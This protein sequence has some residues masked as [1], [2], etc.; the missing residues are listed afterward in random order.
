MLMRAVFFGTPAIAVP[1]LR[2]LTEI[3]HVRAVVCQ[4][5]RPAGRGL[6]LRPPPV[7]AAAQELNLVVHQPKAVKTGALTQWLKEL[8]VDVALVMAYGRILPLD[9]L[10]APR[11]GSLNLHASLL[12]KYRGAAPIQW[13][14]AHGEH[15]TGISLMRMEAGMDTGPVFCRRAVAIGPEETAGQ[16]AERLSLLAAEV[17]RN[18]LARTLSGE[19]V[20]IPQD[21]AAA[22]YAP[23]IDRTTAAVQWTRRAPEIMN[24]V[25]AMAPRPGAHTRI[26]NKELKL[27]QVTCTSGSAFPPGHVSLLESGRVLVAC[28]E[29]AIEIHRAQ[30]EGRR[31]ADARD[32][33]NGRILRSGDTLGS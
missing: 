16:L 8:E 32:L 14:I 31:V 13:A 27:W 18:D 30:L 19:L 20:A 5:D 23:P 6:E 29:G 24:L 9:V 33:I 12:P 25:R 4:P 21:E 11:H 2:A 15:E 1:A 28:G 7:K 26:R 17:T 22:T 10:L 3:A